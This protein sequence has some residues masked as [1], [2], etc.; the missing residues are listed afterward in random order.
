VYPYQPPGVWEALAAGPGYRQSSG[1]DLYR[2]SLYTVWKRSAPPPSAISFD[3]AERLVCTVTRQRTSTP[4]QAL[5]L[6]NDPQYVESARILAEQVL[7]HDGSTPERTTYAFRRV[8]SRTPTSTETQHLAR[9]HDTERA[10]FS[11]ERSAA[12]ALLAT[13]ERPRDPSLDPVDLA[14]W[15]VVTSTIM[16][17]DEAVHTR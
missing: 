7:H 12:E 15:T 6:L 13:G 10:R 1:D 9:L 2:R 8:L 16:N 4:L 5:V 3:A 14:A 17:L 11:A